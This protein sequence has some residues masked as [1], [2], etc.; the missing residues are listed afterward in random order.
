[1]SGRLAFVVMGEPALRSPIINEILGEPVL[2][3]MKDPTDCWKKVVFTYG[4]T[5]TASQHVDGE[6]SRPSQRRVRSPLLLTLGKL[7]FDS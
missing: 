5:R 7:S 2:P 3:N 6:S 4:Q 1:M